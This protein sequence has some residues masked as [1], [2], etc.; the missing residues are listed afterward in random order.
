[1]NL[2]FDVVTIIA[3][4]GIAIGLFLI[5]KI[6]KIITRIFVFLIFLVIAYFSN[7][8]N[9]RHQI[10]ALEKA[11]AGGHKISADAITRKDLKL[12]SLTQ[13]EDEHGIRTIGVGAFFKVFIFKTPT[14]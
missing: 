8:S 3:I 12:A 13:Y 7:P 10:A 11:E 6:F 9:S 4:L 2:P 14:R 5:F 1:M